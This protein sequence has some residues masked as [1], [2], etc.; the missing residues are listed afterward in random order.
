MNIEIPKKFK[1]VI[2]N[3]R[4]VALNTFRPILVYESRCTNMLNRELRWTK[5]GITWEADPRHAEIIVEQLGL[6]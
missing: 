4:Q 2:N 5:E 6:D 1:P 3:A